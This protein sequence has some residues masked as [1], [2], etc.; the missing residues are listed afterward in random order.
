MRLGPRCTCQQGARALGP[1]RRT[2]SGTAAHPHPCT[3]PPC[4][5]GCSPGPG[6]EGPALGLRDAQPAHC[7]GQ[8]KAPRGC[9]ALSVCPCPAHG[10]S[11]P[12][13]SARPGSG[14]TL[15]LAPQEV[16]GPRG[17]HFSASCAGRPQSTGDWQSRA[18]PAH[19]RTRQ[20]PG[21]AVPPRGSSRDRQTRGDPYSCPTAALTS[22]PC[23]RHKL[24]LVTRPWG[25]QSCSDCMGCTLS[26]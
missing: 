12:R 18:L 5:L 10:Q 8:L 26:R 15:Q 4:L 2:P 17:L 16:T 9:S 7:T 19:P 3:G 14:A 13:R 22:W 11:S 1:P 23:T 24:G 21:G 25:P 20:A 6:S